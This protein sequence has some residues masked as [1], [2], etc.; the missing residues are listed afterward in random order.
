MIQG[1]VPPKVLFLFFAHTWVSEWGSICQKKVEGSKGTIKATSFL[2]QSVK[3]IIHWQLAAVLCCAA[4][5]NR[6]ECVVHVTLEQFNGRNRTETDRPP[7]AKRGHRRTVQREE[8]GMH[9]YGRFPGREMKI[10][11]EHGLSLRRK[12]TRKRERA[13]NV[14]RTCYSVALQSNVHSRR[15]GGHVVFE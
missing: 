2:S 15:R 11:S 10:D 7:A 5:G 8:G 6:N 13:T 9:V 4:W 1:N 14:R 12:E 3:L